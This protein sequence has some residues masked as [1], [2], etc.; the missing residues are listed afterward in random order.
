M[1]PLDHLRH[2]YGM[3]ARGV[4]PRPDCAL[5]ERLVASLPVRWLPDWIAARPFAYGL[6]RTAPSPDSSEGAPE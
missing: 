1:T 4:I 6:M 2:R 3:R 5:C